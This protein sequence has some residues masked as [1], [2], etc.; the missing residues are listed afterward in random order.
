MRTSILLLVGMFLSIAQN[1]VAQNRWLVGTGL[2][3]CTYLNSPGINFN[4]S[5][6]VAGNL[7]IGPDFSA[8]LS[9]ERDE[10]G[11]TVKRKEVEYNLNSHYLVQINESISLYPLVG[12]NISKLTIHPEG[13]QPDRKMITALNAGGGFEFEVSALHLF[14]ESKWTSKVDKVDITA[15]LLF[16]L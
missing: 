2:T 7:H 15:G 6:R 12:M 13:E 11:R 4:V 16:E 14:I 3:Y 1:V 5:Y 9:R 8:L 10:D